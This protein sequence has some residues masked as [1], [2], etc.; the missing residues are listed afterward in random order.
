MN[1]A[2]NRFSFF[3]LIVFLYVLFLHWRFADSNSQHTRQNKKMQL[4]TW[5]R[6]AIRIREPQ[7]QQA[8]GHIGKQQLQFGC[9]KERDTK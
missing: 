8:E 7:M 2:Y 9:K 5:E 1:S 6:N 3:L 4:Q